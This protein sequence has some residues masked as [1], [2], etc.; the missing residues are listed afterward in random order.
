MVAV[1]RVKVVMIVVVTVMVSG[2]DDGVHHGD[3][4]GVTMTVMLRQ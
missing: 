2:G 4:E 3:G 1:V